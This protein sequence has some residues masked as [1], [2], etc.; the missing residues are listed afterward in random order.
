M[1][2]SVDFDDEL[3]KDL[4]DSEFK[5]EFD[6]YD[7]QLSDAVDKKIEKGKLNQSKL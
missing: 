3:R 7:G 6:K 5:K 2:N 4:K 1:K